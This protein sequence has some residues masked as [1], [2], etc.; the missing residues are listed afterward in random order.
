MKAIV[1]TDFRFKMLYFL[2]LF[3]IPI[4]V[5]AEDPLPQPIAFSHKL[6]A[7]Q[8]QI[9]C[10]YCH[11]YARRSSVSGIP[12]V[13]ICAGCHGNDQMKLIAADKPEADKVRKYWS[14]KKP[15][16]WE[17]VHDIPDFVRFTHEGHIN[18]SSDRLPEMTK[19]KCDMKK[20]PRSIECRVH[21]FREGGDTRCQACHGEIKSMDVVKKVDEKFGKMGWC[22]EC[23]IQVKDAKARKSALTTLGGWFGA[24][25]QEALREKNIEWKSPEGYHHPNT[26]DCLTCHY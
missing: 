9:A 4:Q 5:F 13:Q 22:L 10:Q 23:H 19:K 17:K 15:I 6:H 7:T 2:M 12:P 25:N 26:H 20:D 16:P 24:K 1:E 18:A 8:N 14:D 3:L 21:Q 11:I